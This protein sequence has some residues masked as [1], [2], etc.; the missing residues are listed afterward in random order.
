MRGL[1]NIQ[2]ALLSDT[3]YVIE[4]N[5]RA[6]RTVPFASKATGVQL[7]KAAALIQV[8]ATIA[9]LRERGMLPDTDAREIHDG[10]SIAVKAAVLPFKRFRT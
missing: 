7:A 3:L 5:P 4:A 2:F 6:S 9:S 10:G 8:G 1:I